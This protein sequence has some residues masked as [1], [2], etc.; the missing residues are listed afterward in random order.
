MLNSCLQS[1]QNPAASGCPTEDFFSIS[2]ACKSSFFT[3]VKA[4]NF[5]LAVIRTTGRGANGQVYVAVI[6]N[7]LH[8]VYFVVLLMG[9]KKLY[10]NYVQEQ[11]CGHSREIP[12]AYWWVGWLALGDVELRDG[13]SSHWLVS[14][15][16][17]PDVS[18]RAS[19]SWTQPSL[20]GIEQVR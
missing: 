7:S 3:L 8:M 16:S 6:L 20:H 14:V 12:G 9:M 17:H 11:S 5:I 2:V 4:H 18:P 10:G 19:L 15:F 13:I 1:W